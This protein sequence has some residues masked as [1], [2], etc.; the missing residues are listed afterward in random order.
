VIL[1]THAGA[2][3]HQIAEVIVIKPGL[4]GP[5]DFHQRTEGPQIPLADRLVK[6]KVDAADG[7]AGLFVKPD[8][9]VQIV[10]I[11]AQL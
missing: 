2:A 5:L 11:D 8:A 3:G 7:F 6:S 9:V 10:K 4:P 1:V